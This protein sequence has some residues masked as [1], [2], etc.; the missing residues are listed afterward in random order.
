MIYVVGDR[1]VQFDV[2]FEGKRNYSALIDD[3]YATGKRFLFPLRLY[4]KDGRY[5]KTISNFGNFFGFAFRK[6]L[7]YSGVC[8]CVGV[9]CICFR[10]ICS[11]VC[12][13]CQRCSKGSG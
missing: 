13:L 12:C 2:E 8:I 11:S 9:L 1:Y 7:C 10:R 4:E 6:R 5:V 3:L